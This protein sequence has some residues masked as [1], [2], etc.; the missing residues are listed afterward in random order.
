MEFELVSLWDEIGNRCLK[1]AKRELEK[2]NA[3]TEAT[4]ETVERLVRIAVSIDT[5]NLHW[6]EFGKPMLRGD[7]IYRQMQQIKRKLGGQ[8][9]EGSEED[10]I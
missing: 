2:E 10:G 3:T 1:L 7:N 9:K 4:V 5:L 6:A 8:S